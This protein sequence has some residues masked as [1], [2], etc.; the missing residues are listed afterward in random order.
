MHQPRRQTSHH[1]VTR[2]AHEPH[3]AGQISRLFGRI[4]RRSGSGTAA[5]ICRQ[6][7][8][9]AFNVLDRFAKEDIVLGG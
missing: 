7:V 1:L 9:V 5:A 6:E 4:R 3:Q 8:R 2:A